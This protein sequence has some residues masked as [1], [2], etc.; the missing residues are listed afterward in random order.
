MSTI[1]EHVEDA[2]AGISQPKAASAYQAATGADLPDTY[3]VYLLVSAP[4]LQH[5]DDAETLRTYTVQVSIY[6]R[7][8]LASLPDIETPLLAAGFLRGPEREIPYNPL[9]GHYGVAKEFTFTE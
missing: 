5:A 1:W 2:L 4:P 6:S 9:T 8:G 7:T 3:L